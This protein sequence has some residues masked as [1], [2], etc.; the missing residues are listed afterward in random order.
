MMQPTNLMQGMYW[1]C[2]DVL[3][4][5]VRLSTAPELPEPEEL[6]L[7]IAGLLEQM[8]SKAA[9][10][11][12]SRD[13]IEDARYA[14]VAF[15]DEQILQSSWQGKQDWLLEP[16]QLRYFNENTAGEGFFVRLKAIESRPERTHVLQLYFLC[17]ALGFQG[18]YVVKGPTAL[19][20]LIESLGAK[21]G[22]SLPV[23]DSVS[24]HGV[25]PDVGRG[26]ASKQVPVIALAIVM[27]VIAVGLFA[28]LRVALSSTVAEATTSLHKSAS[29]VSGL[30]KGGR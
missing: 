20:A 26:R 16:L 18:M 8:T 30:A 9:E 7:R 1:S 22:R 23:T 13:D 28:G 29:E 25:P 5:G 27:L 11:G 6:R 17:L 14:L 10:A 21:L 3:S 2:A 4:L 15:L 12:L 24:P 19:S